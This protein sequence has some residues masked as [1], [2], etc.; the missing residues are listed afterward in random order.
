M[1]SIFKRSCD[2]NGN[3]EKNN[4]GFNTGMAVGIAVGA[5]VVLFAIFLVAMYYKNYLINKKEVQDLEK[6]ERFAP[7]ETDLPDFPDHDYY[8]KEG[9]ILH[10]KM[11]S[12][13]DRNHGM[14]MSRS[15][16]LELPIPRMKE[17][18]DNASIHSSLS[19]AQ[20]IQKHPHLD[21]IVL[22][23]E[24]E[25]HSTQGLDQYAKIL[26]TDYKAYSPGFAPTISR[27]SSAT[28]V[29][30]VL[31][32]KKEKYDSE[33]ESSTLNDPFSL[34]PSPNEELFNSEK[35]P[36]PKNSNLRYQLTDQPSYVKQYPEYEPELVQ[37]VPAAEPKKEPKQEL[38][39]EKNLQLS[40]NMDR[41]S[42]FDDFEDSDLTEA[43][44]EHLRKTNSVYNVY[45][46]RNPSM[47]RGPE[48]PVI[49]DQN[50]HE[51]PNIE[52][53]YSPE[54]VEQK[55][56]SAGQIKLRHLTDVSTASSNYET[57]NQHDFQGEL[58]NLPETVYEN[59]Q[60]QQYHP[61]EAQQSN[62]PP[63]QYHENSQ[64][65]QIQ[66]LQIHQTQLQHT[67]PAPLVP[68]KKLPTASGLGD[69]TNFFE[70]EAAK[71]ATSKPKQAVKPFNPLEHSESWSPNPNTTGNGKFTNPANTRNSPVTQPL[72]QAPSASMISRS[73]I[74]MLNTV[75]LTAAKKYRPANGRKTLPQLQHNPQQFSQPLPNPHVKKAG[76]KGS[77]KDLRKML[78][79]PMFK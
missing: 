56:L 62:Y 23:F 64:N 32:S 35:S 79:D 6:D 1:S 68:L 52:E 22:P 4:G 40:P 2:A 42:K 29:S 20:T 54:N 65:N 43:E 24:G 15:D 39:V 27:S 10:P 63:V 73:S 71:K 46:D 5:P 51:L 41:Y 44:K 14:K 53:V 58:P 50:Q 67:P 16:L 18:G 74:L 34:L 55:T 59:H 21:S 72:Q 70:F 12:R 19:M 3:C 7:E 77:S 76:A 57:F 66:P 17:P 36:E 28:D 45:F 25:R 78:D 31:A 13:V 69:G 8:A 48:L 49:D 37:P 60:G 33:Y 11:K 75:D 47:K 30:S 26:G 38:V 9:G 61:Q